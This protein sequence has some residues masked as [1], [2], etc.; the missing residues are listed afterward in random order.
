MFVG[1]TFALLNFAKK[2]GFKEQIQKL[3]SREILYGIKCRIFD[4]ITSYRECSR[5]N[6]DKNKVGLSD[7]KG[8]GFLDFGFYTSFTPKMS[9]MDLPKKSSFLYFD[10]IFNPK[11]K[12]FVSRGS[13]YEG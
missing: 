2:S 7:I 5:N 12:K 3:F 6:P 10:I 11:L 13:I 1:N 8:F 9:K 4:F